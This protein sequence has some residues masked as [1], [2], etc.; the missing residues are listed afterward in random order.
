MNDIKEKEVSFG[1]LE[2]KIA[3]PSLN[4]DKTMVVSVNFTEL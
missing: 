2:L 3:K 1:E 4:T